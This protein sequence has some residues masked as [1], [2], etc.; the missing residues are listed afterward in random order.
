M[1][2]SYPFNIIDFDV[3]FPDNTY[4][5]IMTVCNDNNCGKL[6]YTH[7]KCGYTFL[8]S[9][10]ITEYGEYCNI[11]IS[12]W[13]Y[14][15]GTIAETWNTEPKMMKPID[16]TDDDG[17][18]IVLDM[19]DGLRSYDLFDRKSMNMKQHWTLDMRWYGPHVMGRCDGIEAFQNDYQIK[20]LKAF[21]NRTGWLGRNKVQYSQGNY[22]ASMGYPSMRMSHE[23][24]FLGVPATGNDIGPFVMDFWTVRNRKCHQNWVIIDI[25]S[26]LRE[27]SYEMRDSI[28]KAIKAFL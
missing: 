27:T 21:P 4:E 14:D 6:F 7:T 3:L 24:D 13:A 9:S 1:I 12:Q 10:Q 11:D 26:I 17:L 19:I 5:H 2:Y 16:R 8:A 18:P 20:W 22:V 15:K 25:L 28:D 23:G